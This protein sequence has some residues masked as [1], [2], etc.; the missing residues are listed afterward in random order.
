MIQT[1]D[2]YELAAKYHLALPDRIR[3]YLNSRGIPDMQ[4]DMHLLGWTGRRIAIPIYNSNNELVFFRFA[5]D[6]E[7]KGSGPKMMSMRGSYVELYGWEE[8]GRRPR[9]VIICEGEFDRLVL[10]ANGFIAVTSTGG[11]ATF[12]EE[13]AVE[14]AGIS[15]VYICYDQ[16]SA[17]RRG[18]LKVG[19]MIPHAKLVTLPAE[20][21]DGGDVTDYFVRLGKTR[22][23]LITLLKEAAPVPPRPEPVIS[24]DPPKSKT[25]KSVDRTRIDRIKETTSIVDLVGRYVKLSMSGS[26]LLGRCP[27]HNDKTPSLAVFPNTHTFY[28]FGCQ[29][30]GDVIRF[31]Q[32]I[33][34]LS[35]GQALDALDSVNKYHGQKAEPGT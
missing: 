4:I 28:C 11:A 5:K 9:Y 20:V 3:K 30:H 33:E 7:S 6:P 31:I 27:F 22:E 8:I 14:F 15:E 34:H 13:W 35:F 29:K 26:T 18:A 12:T 16:D 10:E 2:L 19:L 25:Q 1:R 21:G 24:Y 32:E 23:D 17:G